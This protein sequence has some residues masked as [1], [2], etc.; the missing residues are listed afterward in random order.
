M[1]YFLPYS[2]ADSIKLRGGKNMTKLLFYSFIFFFC[3]TEIVR[4]SPLSA[5]GKGNKRLDV[6]VASLKVHHLMDFLPF[7]MGLLMDA[8]GKTLLAATGIV[9]IYF[10]VLY[11]LHFLLTFFAL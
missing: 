10:A 5:D 6:G 4:S 8:T 2:G 1:Y 11:V 3:Q 9:V 7:W